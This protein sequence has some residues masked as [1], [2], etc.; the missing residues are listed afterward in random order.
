V[1][2]R[3]REPHAVVREA[4]HYEGLWRPLAPTSPAAAPGDDGA[5]LRAMGRSLDDYAAAIGGTK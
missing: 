4:A 5:A 3:S 1:H 2:G